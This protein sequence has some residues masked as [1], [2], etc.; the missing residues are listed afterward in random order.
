MIRDDIWS[1]ERTQT[2]KRLWIEGKSAGQIAD[3]L[4]NGATRSGVIGKLTR[5]GV[6]GAKG[7]HPRPKAPRDKGNPNSARR[8][9][10][11]TFAIEPPPPGIV[12][13]PTTFAPEPTSPTPVVMVDLKAHHCRWP[14]GDTNDPDFHFCGARKIEPGPY[15][16]AH[17]KRA[18]VPTSSA[19]DLARSVRRYAA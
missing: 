8:T 10:K 13:P 16:Q 14:I 6:A 17:A 11:V 9:R 2:A 18:F 7:S 1:D 12:R 5:L 3:Q 19:S 15:C 4:K